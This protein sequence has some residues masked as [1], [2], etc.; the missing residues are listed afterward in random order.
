MGQSGKALDFCS[1][2]GGKE[3]EPQL[4]RLMCA[5][6]FKGQPTEAPSKGI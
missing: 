3:G 6:L 5:V 1:W 4:L 2:G